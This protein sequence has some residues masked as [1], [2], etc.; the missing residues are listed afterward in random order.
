MVNMNLVKIE[1]K[2]KHDKE[3]GGGHKIYVG[4]TDKNPKPLS[5]KLLLDNP[6][7]LN[8]EKNPFPFE[9]EILDAPDMPDFVKE[10]VLV[11]PVKEVKKQKSKEVKSKKYSK[12][13]LEKMS[14]GRLKEIAKKFSETGRS[15]LGLIK[16]ILKHLQ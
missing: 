16:D 4:S 1:I 11:E 6:G 12:S 7:I 10:I 13:D 15:K 9:G 8:K 2:R 14:F 5:I 3:Y